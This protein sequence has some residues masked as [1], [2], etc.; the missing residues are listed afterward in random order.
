MDEVSSR[1]TTF[2]APFG[3]WKVLPFGIVPAQEIFQKVLYNNVA[4]LEG[5]VNK[6]DD[7]LVVGKGKTIE[8]STAVHENKLRKLLQRCR[9]RGMQ[10]NAEKIDLR[11][12]S[13]FYGTYSDQ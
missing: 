1:L 13:M 11:Q 2:T 12:I 6:V 5:V 3:R 7:L 4:D 10:I 9:E 8:K